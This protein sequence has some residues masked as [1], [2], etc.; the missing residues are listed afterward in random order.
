MIYNILNREKFSKQKTEN[1]ESL[2]KVEQKT[3]K[4]APKQTRAATKT[5]ELETT[6]TP[7]LRR[8]RNIKNA[9]VQETSWAKTW[10]EIKE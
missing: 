10:A 1:Q 3:K 4:M 6:E 8:L 7:L 2:I 9:K 5:K